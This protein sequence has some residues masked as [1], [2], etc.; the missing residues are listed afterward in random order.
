MVAHTELGIYLPTFMGTIALSAP[1]NGNTSASATITSISSVP[2]ELRGLI[3]PSVTPSDSAWVPSNGGKIKTECGIVLGNAALGFVKPNILDI[4]LGARLWADDAPPAKRLRQDKGAAETTS[5][6]LGFRLEGMRV[7][8]GP[9][10]GVLA[11][12]KTDGYKTYDK[13]YGRSL[14]P[15]TVHEGF[16]HYFVVEHAGITKVFAEEIIARFIE[17]LRGLQT[18][19]EKEECRI[20]SSSL[21]FVYEG[22]GKALQEAFRTENQTIARIRDRGSLPEQDRE[23]SDSDDEGPSLPQIQTLKL[24]DFAHARWMPGQGPDENLLNGLSSVI[25]A[26]QDLR[27]TIGTKTTTCWPVHQICV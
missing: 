13:A 27:D 20:Y 19:V 23:S 15:D 1:P 7:W 26:L 25:K 17:D 6:S 2:Q 21:L 12:D 22:D 24:I 11:D 16:E 10:V 8:Q 5:L 3:S 4:K 9:E 18:A 14:T